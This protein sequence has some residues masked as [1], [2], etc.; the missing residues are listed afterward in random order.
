[1]DIHNYIIY[2]TMDIDNGIYYTLSLPSATA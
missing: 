1:M 2:S